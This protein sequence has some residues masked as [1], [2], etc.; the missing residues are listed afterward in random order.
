MI[1]S[2]YGFVLVTVVL[3]LMPRSSLAI[4]IA[5][6]DYNLVDLKKHIIVIPVRHVNEIEART[7]KFNEKEA[8]DAILNLAQRYASSADPS[9]RPKSVKILLELPVNNTERSRSD[10]FRAHIDEFIKKNKPQGITAERFDFRSADEIYKAFFEYVDDM[11]FL[12]DKIKL[13]LSKNTKQH[14]ELVLVSMASAMANTIQEI[15]ADRHQSSSGQDAPGYAITWNELFSKLDEFKNRLELL[16]NSTQTKIVKA[17]VKVLLG[18]VASIKESVQTVINEMNLNRSTSIQGSIAQKLISTLNDSKI[19]PTRRIY[20]AFKLMDNF[21]EKISSPV[22][23][24]VGIVIDPF[25]VDLIDSS[26][27]ENDLTIVVTGACHDFENEQRIKSL[28]PNVKVHR[29]ARGCSPSYV[30]SND[31]LDRGAKD[32]SILRLHG[33]FPNDLREIFDKHLL[34]PED[35]NSLIFRRPTEKLSTNEEFDMSFNNDAQKIKKL[36]DDTRVAVLEKVKPLF[37]KDQSENLTLKQII[38][39]AK[40]HPD[41]V[42]L[43]A[44]ASRMVNT[45]Q[46]ITF[47]NSKSSSGKDSPEDK[48]WRDENTSIQHSIT[49][50]L[51]SILNDSK[52]TPARRIYSAF[53]LMDNCDKKV[54]KSIHDLIVQKPAAK[55]AAECLS[56]SSV[57][58]ISAEMRKIVEGIVAHI[59][60]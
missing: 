47:D 10:E 58:A 24:L 5:V 59:A 23:G 22:T 1:K 26:T 9:G 52:N 42:D 6:T 49:Q 44:I 27:K 51:I 29:A 41:L 57:E 50:Q 34:N 18:H 46:K 12:L 54:S 45:L 53:E 38:A 36:F 55:L 60:Q 43:A 15:T 14:P 37:L 30:T 25:L 4:P 20:S 56:Q 2:Q 21:Q 11:K 19:S 8:S 7:L 33:L 48:M 39:K 28:Y 17:G 35:P 16:D 3:G 40:Q 31:F 13:D 32:L